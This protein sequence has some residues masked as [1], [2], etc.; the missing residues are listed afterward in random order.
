MEKINL[1]DK[2]IFNL[3][4]L[5]HKGAEANLY[6]GTYLD[7]KC[8]FKI[9]KPKKYRNKDLDKKIR[10]RRTHSETMI[11]MKA[12]ES[13][14]RT[15]IIWHIDLENYVIIMEFIEGETIRDEIMNEKM[16]IES[17][18][19]LLAFDVAS[20]HNINLVHGDL[21]TSN[22]LITQNKITYLDFGLGMISEDIEEKAVEIDLLSRV[23]ASTHPNITDK[24]FP[25]FIKEYI[26]TY[27]YGSD[28][29]NRVEKISKQGRYISKRI[30]NL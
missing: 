30:R 14:I 20:L 5:I 24:F 17:F 2:Y 23:I 12:R 3:N 10:K 15:P 6:I 1:N 25:I 8:V 28:V 7:M 29:M 26:K 13:G 19:R 11:Q 21:T 9:R 18:A 16:E 4:R 22:L 27:E